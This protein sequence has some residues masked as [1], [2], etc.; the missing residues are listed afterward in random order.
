MPKIDIV[1]KEYSE[2][3]NIYAYYINSFNALYQ[4]KTRN[5]EEI[6]SIYEMIKTN[7]I[8]SKKY[9]PENIVKDIFNII[10]YNNRYT[11][12]YLKLAKLIF[13]E[14]NVKTVID[15]PN[16]FSS[17]FY[18]EYGINLNKSNEIENTELENLEIFPENSIYNAIMD[19]DLK[20]FISFTER[21]GFNEDQRLNCKFY[22]HSVDGYSL[23]ELCCYYGAVDCFKFLRTKFDSEITLL[24]LKDTLTCQIFC[25][26]EEV[27]LDMSYKPEI[28]ATYL[29]LFK[30]Q[31]TLIFKNKNILFR[32]Y[33][34]ILCE[35]YI[36]TYFASVTFFFISTLYDL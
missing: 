12:S 35:I 33:I 2:L 17:L 25:A 26:Y 5:D 31:Y 6:N 10:P 30:L 4:L 28:L 27:M 19:N 9:L 23:L 15:T 34:I 7:L 20:R 14:Y 21:D 24:C 8:D 18:K 13:D 3:R 11:K 29:K 22:P 16:V 1:P 32:N 36:K